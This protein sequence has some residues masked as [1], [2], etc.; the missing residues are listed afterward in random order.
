MPL[1]FFSYVTIVPVYECIV[2]FCRSSISVTWNWRQWNQIKQSIKFPH[3]PGS[4]S[5]H[6]LC[7]SLFTTNTDLQCPP[8]TPRHPA[9]LI[10]GSSTAHMPSRTCLQCSPASPAVIKA[11]FPSSWPACGE[12]HPTPYA[13][14]SSDWPRKPKPFTR[15]NFPTIDISRERRRIRSAL[16]R[17][18][19]S[20][21][22]HSAKPSEHDA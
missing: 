14:S 5:F 4:S 7:F 1:P 20:K 19:S 10:R 3:S 18:P 8:R 6:L 17:W 9:H 11:T 22:S 16:K 15:F 21:R 2:F 13:Q 12:K